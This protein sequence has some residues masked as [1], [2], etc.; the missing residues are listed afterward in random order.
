M[1]T[2][3]HSTMLRSSISA[4]AFGIG[5]SGLPSD[6]LAEDTLTTVTT[7]AIE[8]TGEAEV[9]FARGSIIVAPIPL[10]NPA[11]GNGVIAVGGFLF[12]L[13]D[14][15]DTSFVGVARM[16]TD[17]GS[18]GTGIAAN[19]FLGEGRWQLRAAYGQATVN[20][21]VSGVGRFRFGPIPI[22][23]KGSF[24]T[25]KVSYGVTEKFRL[26]L[27][28]AHLETT[29]R[30]NEPGFTLPALPSFRGGGIEQVLVTPQIIWD[31][32]DDNFYPTEGLYGSWKLQR[33]YGIGSFDNRFTKH[34]LSGSAYIPTSDVGVLA[35]D[36]TAC[37]ASNRTP[38][39]NLCAVGVTDSL[40]GFGAG[41]YFENSLLTV[42]AEYRHRISDRWG[43]SIF[44]GASIIGSSFDDIGGSGPLYA[45]G[46]GVRYRLS[47]KFPLDFSVDYTVNSNND[48]YTYVF[49]GQAF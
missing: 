10:S 9:G 7:S 45:G 33:G 14:Q 25:A 27:D 47:K 12:K 30:L 11:L 13:D 38:F 8:T 3:S 44:G 41:E 17:N 19:V 16:K 29:I 6:A 32:R 34:V 21:S 24:A 22:S 36:V 31:T 20:Y 39:F 40:R 37:D 48:Q 26:G 4:A 2:G 23:Q 5:L 49:L 1:I 15:S 35:L 43:A 42:Q 46:L 18:Q 28:L